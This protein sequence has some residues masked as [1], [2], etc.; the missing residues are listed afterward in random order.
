MSCRI[1]Q[2][3][4]FTVSLLCLFVLISCRKEKEKDNIQTSPTSQA[5]DYEP[6]SNAHSLSYLGSPLI[7]NLKTK[8]GEDI[9]TVAVGNDENFLYLTYTLEPNW[10]L[11]SVQTYAGK[12]IFIPVT[13]NGNPN[14][15]QFPG[16]QS[17]NPCDKLQT[18]SFR[19]AMSALRSDESSYCP[20]NA[21]FFVAMRATARYIDNNT[22]CS[23]GWE[24]DAWAAP[25]LINPGNADEWAT[26]IYYCIQESDPTPPSWC[27]YG[28]GYW[29]A[30]PNVVWCQSGVS[31]GNL[32]VAKDEA[33]ALWPAMNNAVKKAFFQASAIQLSWIC[34]NNNEPMPPAV[35]ADYNLLVSFLS[36]LSYEDIQSGNVPAGVNMEEIKTATGN[37][38]RWICQNKCSN[39]EDPTVCGD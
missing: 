35:S 8:T 27:G 2:W 36:G 5:S 28:Q 6:L 32:S 37:V 38:G 17:L 16:K 19:V 1:H 30:K 7:S 20:S 21:Q 4:Q 15:L 29:F 10:Y 23:M 22:S 24:Q 14:H 25:F 33:R 34:Q 9:G 12:K 39:T 31:F 13:E 3:K 11:T 18:F 26:A